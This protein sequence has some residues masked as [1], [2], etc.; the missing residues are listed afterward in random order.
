MADFET[1]N[2][3]L[4]EVDRGTSPSTPFVALTSVTVI[5]ALAVAAVIGVV[6]AAIF[7]AG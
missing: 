2:E 1:H 4:R 7:I 5:V 6:I 3:T